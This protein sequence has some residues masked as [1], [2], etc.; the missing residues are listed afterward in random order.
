MPTDLQPLVMNTLG[1]NPTSEGRIR[2]VFGWYNTM[3]KLLLEPFEFLVSIVPSTLLAA[4]DIN[5]FGH[6]F[7]RTR[8]TS[9]W[10]RSCAG[11]RDAKLKTQLYNNG[12]SREIT[13]KITEVAQ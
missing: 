7:R 11:R 2:L 3:S 8:F 9:L 13:Q 12:N 10:L 6:R 5:E 4:Y 1:T